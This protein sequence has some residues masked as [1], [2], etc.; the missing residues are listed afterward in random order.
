MNFFVTIW[1]LAQG[2]GITMRNF[3]RPKVT[4]RY[5]E[6]RGEKVWFER[7]RAE[8][9]MP[10][11]ADNHHRCTACG[12]CEKACPNATIRVEKR[13]PKVLESYMYDV[14]S[15]MFCALCVEACPFGAIE[16]DNKFEHAMFERDKLVRRL[17]HEGS[18]LEENGKLKMEN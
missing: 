18:S 6:N 14:G 15:C 5:P 9:T 17:N 10:H 1:R 3:L 4:E 8:L 7:F 11:D 2:L 16:F 13:A 12:L